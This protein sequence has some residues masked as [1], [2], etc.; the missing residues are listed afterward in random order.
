MAL[1]TLQRSDAQIALVLASG[2]NGTHL[3][4]PYEVP[5]FQDAGRGAWRP[6][7]KILIALT[8]LGTVRVAITL[9]QANEHSEDV[10]EAYQRYHDVADVTL[11][12]SGSLQVNG[13]AGRFLR[14]KLDFREP[15]GAVA[16]LSIR[17][18]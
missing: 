15:L 3:I 18:A 9:Q 7:E 17:A 4:G 13:I 6:L 8:S 5:A 2:T 10:N 16:R 11:T 14:V 12:E 1:D